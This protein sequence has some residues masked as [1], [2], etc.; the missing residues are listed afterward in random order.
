MMEDVQSS[1]AV[2]DSKRRRRREKDK[3][4]RRAKRS[5]QLP[6]SFMRKSAELAE[7]PGTSLP[8]VP[9]FP[10]SPEGALFSESTDSC[11]DFYIGEVHHSVACQ[12]ESALD[13]VGSVS[14]WPLLAE[15]EYMDHLTAAKAHIVDLMHAIL[16]LTSITEHP[17]EEIEYLE[18]L[19]EQEMALELQLRDKEL[20]DLWAYYQSTATTTPSRDGIFL[21]SMD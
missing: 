4:R 7:E 9:A 14:P 12:T 3:E 8:P 19:T 15:A 17:S 13:H 6:G 11:G 1:T 10:I 20:E 16:D 18:S 2:L 21:H 5:E